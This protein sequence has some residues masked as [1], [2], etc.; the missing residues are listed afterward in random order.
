M[1]WIVW[2]QA[3]NKYDRLYFFGMLFLLLSI[4][5]FG[6]SFYI[7]FHLVLGWHYEIPE[8]IPTWQRWFYAK[9]PFTDS[10]INLIIFGIFFVS[11]AIAGFI[12]N[13]ISHKVED[14]EEPFTKPEPIL[15]EKQN[16]SEG[17]DFFLKILLL[18]L[19]VFASTMVFE[20]LIEDKRPKPIMVIP[21][22]I[23][24]TPIGS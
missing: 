6:F 1:R 11:A 21:K 10:K 8:F 13:K 14:L 17:F 22:T 12:A 5:L 24:S 2:K 15:P 9:L 3:P 18:I 19:V 4:T 23:I 20:W 16:S 7:F